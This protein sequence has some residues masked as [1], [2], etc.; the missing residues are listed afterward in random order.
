MHLTH[1][2]SPETLLKWSRACRAEV[3]QYISATP[4]TKSMQCI[5]VLSTIV[6][7]IAH[8]NPQ[9]QMA[10]DDQIATY[11]NDAGLPQAGVSGCNCHSLSC[12]ALRCGLWQDFCQLSVLHPKH[13]CANVQVHVSAS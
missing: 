2:T 6:Q 3:L 10:M 13:W 9:L 5:Q 11:I 4:C 12:A 7:R 1:L 8:D